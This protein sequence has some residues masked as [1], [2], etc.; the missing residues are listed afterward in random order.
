[1]AIG[2]SVET[3]I[4]KSAAERDLAWGSRFVAGYL[5]GFPEYLDQIDQQ[6]AGRIRKMIFDAV[7]GAEDGE[8]FFQ[9]ALAH[10]MREDIQTKR[11]WGAGAADGQRY[12]QAL[13]N[14]QEA[15]GCFDSLAIFIEMSDLKQQAL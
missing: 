11:G 2:A 12:F 9:A 1:M 8:R 15:T 3:C 5:L 4:R 14:K 7:L 10:F 13:E 6:F